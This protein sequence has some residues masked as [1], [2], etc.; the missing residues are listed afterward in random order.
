MKK[1]FRNEMSERFV[2]HGEQSRMKVQLPEG[3]LKRVD[4]LVA[5]SNLG[6][7]SRAELV[8]EAVRLRVIDLEWLILQKNSHRPFKPANK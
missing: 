4:Y 8:R 1:E 2:K 6:Y 7:S 3:L 5:E